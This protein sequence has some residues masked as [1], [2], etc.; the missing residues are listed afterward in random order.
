MPR[1]LRKLQKEFEG[2]EFGSKARGH[3]HKMKVKHQV[4]RRSYALA[5]LLDEDVLWFRY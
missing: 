5:Q 4:L 3:L 1:E 2:S